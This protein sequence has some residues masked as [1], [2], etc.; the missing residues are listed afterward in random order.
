MTS[1]SRR[2]F[3][4]STLSLTAALLAAAPARVARAD[5]VD[6]LLRDIARA[7]EKLKTLA[8]GFRQERVLG[9]LATTVVSQGELTLVRPDRMRWELKPPDEAIYWVTPE[10]VAY[11]TPQGSGKASPASA[12]A[13][14]AILDDLLT[15]LGGDLGKLKGRY[16]IS[17][18][19]QKEGPSLALVPR[20]ERVAKVIKR[21]QVEL[22]PDLLA[23][24]RLLLEEPGDD[25]AT[26]TFEPARINP[27][28]DPAKMR[29]S[30]SAA[31]AAP[32]A[33]R[34]GSG[35]Q[36]VRDCAG[37]ERARERARER[38]RIHVRHRR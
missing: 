21:L 14:G 22:R 27:A 31:P 32:A 26:I 5:D 24:R 34:L 3:A 18:E 13:L 6:D 15:L 17:V 37:H 35:R 36:L 7:R 9:L 16:A 19:R 28:V 20:V 2:R 30:L 8:C 11:R 29:P 33:E 23:P 38:G 4:A 12:G 1:I 10:G 25:R